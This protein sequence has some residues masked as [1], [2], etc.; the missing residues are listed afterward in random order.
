MAWAGD[1]TV[2]S[3]TFPRNRSVRCIWSGVTQRQGRQ[4][5]LEDLADFCH[6]SVA[7]VVGGIIAIKARSIIAPG[8]IDNSVAHEEE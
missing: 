5:A 6:W 4:E 8:P 2:S 3:G 7:E 1:V